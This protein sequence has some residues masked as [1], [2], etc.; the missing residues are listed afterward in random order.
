MN[1]Q[2]LNRLMI[3]QDTGGAI[4]GAVR[5]DIYWGSGEKA[6]DLA[7]QTKQTGQMWSLLPN[8]VK[9]VIRQ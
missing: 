8:G 3:A 1:E 4:R 9:P 2:P 7:G 6:G 5:A